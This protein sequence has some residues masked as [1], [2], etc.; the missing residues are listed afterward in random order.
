MGGDHP[1][2]SAVSNRRADHIDPDR[3]AGWSGG[4]GTGDRGSGRKRGGITE[5]MFGDRAILMVEGGM[6]LRRVVPMNDTDGART[7]AHLDP[8]GKAGEDRVEVAFA[9][10]QNRCLRVT[11][12]DLLTRKE[13]LRNVPV[14]ELR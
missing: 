14:V 9:V 7:V 13:L 1:R 2:R 3:I 5:V 4:A 6:E 10:D 8:P 12:M 11:V